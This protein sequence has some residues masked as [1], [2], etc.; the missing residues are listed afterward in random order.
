MTELME[1]AELW[2]PVFVLHEYEKYLPL[3]FPTYIRGCSLIDVKT[4]EKLVEYPNLTPEKLIDPSIN[5]RLTQFTPTKDIAL[6]LEDFKGESFFGTP[7]DQSV[8]IYVFINNIDF[9]NVKYV[10]IVYCVMFGYNEA[11]KSIF[12][13]NSENHV[14]DLEWVT[15]RVKLSDKSFNS[16]FFS[17]HGGGGWYNETQV[18]FKDG[19]PVAFLAIGSHSMWPS[20]GT[21][22]RMLGFGNDV[23]TSKPEAEWRIPKTNIVLLTDYKQ[24]PFPTPG[25]E[26]MAFVGSL[27]QD[28]S[29]PI[30]SYDDRKLDSISYKPYKALELSGKFLESKVDF[31]I[32]N[33]LITIFTLLLLLIL[34]IQFFALRDNLT[35]KSTGE[36][37]VIFILTA[38]LGFIGGYSRL[39]L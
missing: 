31:D 24:K 4:S 18:S 21:H 13:F 6:N 1:L 26:Y 25:Y 38:L 32:K 8:P 29:S 27:S 17:A 3:S 10:D 30:V 14:F 19:H 11:P 34:T 16:A 15:V 22:I 35:W 2:K 9:E 37:F 36:Q 12:T 28:V 39:F 7:I 5:S 20:G 33:R 23:C